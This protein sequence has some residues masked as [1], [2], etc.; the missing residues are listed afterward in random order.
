[1]TATVRHW[2]RGYQHDHRSKRGVE[3][4]LHLALYCQG[5]YLSY[6]V[7]QTMAT[8]LVDLGSVDYAIPDRDKHTFQL[9]TR[10]R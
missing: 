6:D 4:A 8:A 10:R 1:M 9:V 3:H 2:R 7:K 5:L